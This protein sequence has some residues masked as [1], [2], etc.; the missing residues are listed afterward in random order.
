MKKGQYVR[1]P[2]FLE[3]KD[4]E[5]PR[6]FILAQ[7]SSINLIAV[8]VTVEIHD[9]RKSKS[10]F[11]HA[12]I[13]T[14]FPMGDIERCPAARDAMVIAPAGLGTVLSVIKPKEEDDFYQYYIQLNNGEIQIYPE[15]QIQIEYTAMDYSPV[16]QMLKY[17]FQHPSWYGSRVMV[18]QNMHRA[19]NTIYGFKALLGC[20]AFLMAHQISSVVRMFESRPIRYMLADEVGL[21]KTIEACS[22]VKILATEKQ[23]LRVLYVVPGALCHQWKNE[24]W[25]KFGIQASDNPGRARLENHLILSMEELIS[26]DHVQDFHWDMLIVDETHRVLKKEEL[27]DQLLRLSRETKNVLLLSATPIQSR[28]NEYLR[29]LTLLQPEQYGS[30][31]ATRFSEI[32]NKQKKIQKR[33]NVLISHMNQYQDYKEDSRDRIDE[34]SEELED[35]NLI[36]MVKGIQLDSEDEGREALEAA[37]SYVSEN[38]R[39]ER[40]IIR[41]RREYINETLGQRKLRTVSYEMKNMEDGYCENNVYYTVLEVL[42]GMMNDGKLHTEQLLPCLQALFSSPWALSQMLQNYGIKDSSILSMVNLWEKQAD[43]ELR[44]VDHLLDE[45]PYKIKGR[46]LNV[47]DFVEQEISAGEGD[48][49]KIVIF[50]QFPETLWK[51]GEMLEHRGYHSV[52]FTSNMLQDELEDSVYEFQNDPTCR[53]ILCDASGGEG[54]NFQ[55]ADWIV[56]LDLPWTAN[57]IEQRIGRLDRLGRDEKHLKVRSVV[58]YSKQTIEE[59][60]FRVWNEGLHLFEKSLSGMEII[61]GDLNERIEEAIK[62]DIYNGLENALDEIME[63]MEDTIDAVEEE[64]LY[65]SGR[66]IYRSLNHAIQQML[67]T[68]TGGED[69]V[70]EESMVG[71]AKHSG[72]RCKRDEKGIS[73]FSEKGF[74]PMAAIQSLLIPP[75]WSRYN[76]TSVVRKQGKILGTF[77]RDVSILREDL[78]F[79]APGDPVFDSIIMNALVS[80]RGRCCAVSGL[81]SFSFHGFCFTYGIEPNINS[82]LEHHVPLQLLSQFRMYLPMEQIKILIPVDGSEN[83]PTEEV[84]EYLSNSTAMRDSYHLGR[85]SGSTPPLLQFMADYPKEDWQGIVLRA[86]KKAVEKAREQI[87]ARADFK[88]AKQEIYRILHGYQSQLIYLGK[89]QSEIERAKE[90]YSA[91]YNAL[92]TSKL[93]LDSICYLALGR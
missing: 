32:L 87:A 44:D 61:T 26:S 7:I 24:L 43:E 40:N 28:E 52:L 55:N 5:Y 13:K 89:D 14:V 1:C 20:R 33:V 3:E 69:N 86:Q 6:N 83:I 31:E 91:V 39:I 49:G 79:Y 68:Y 45:E 19:S 65:D 71:W 10:F 47:M 85:R 23:D 53:A 80:G 42:S 51:F 29:L 18:S 16:H 27:Y 15:D 66:V 73:E 2:I 82:L 9:L 12:F 34:L 54:R 41:N 56:H 75:D 74:S 30:M 76:N 21:G 78:I 50:S 60:L 4:Q 11:P 70:F 64:Q 67:K 84:L 92:K 37:I 36:R 88:T 72:L 57:D 8:E 22:V 59:Q 48:N 46:L 25:Y 17:E 38:Y 35:K 81:T 77:E 62:D 63:M 93:K 90:D 58:V